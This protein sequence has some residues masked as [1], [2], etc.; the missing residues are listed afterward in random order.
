[1]A[2]ISL[3]YFGAKYFL[4][5]NLSLSTTDT[6][7]NSADELL[8]I[9]SCD[10][11]AITHDMTAKRTLNGGG[12]ETVTQLGQSISEGSISLLRKGTGDVY[13]ATGGTSTYARLRD[14][15]TAAAADGGATAEKSLVE[16]IPRGSGAYEG[17]VYTVIPTSFTPGVR[18]T[19]NGQEYS[20]GIKAYSAPVP[21]DVTVTGTTISIKKHTTQTQT[22]AA[23]EP[24]EG[25]GN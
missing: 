10:V 6:A 19:E 4:V 15:A 2:E 9:M 7:L 23:E 1:M 22:P 20:V 21:V 18:D 25:G 16:L 17:T 11:G 13:Q 8:D 3:S 12:W 14:W 24:A 5:S